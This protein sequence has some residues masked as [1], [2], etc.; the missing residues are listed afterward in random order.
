M[1][2]NEHELRFIAEALG[3]EYDVVRHG[4]PDYVITK[5][6]E[7]LFVEVKPEK[8][9][10]SGNAELLSVN[11][12]RMLRT[13]E[14]A[15]LKVRISIGGDL[16]QLYTLG[17]YLKLTKFKVQYRSR[18]DDTDKWIKKVIPLKRKVS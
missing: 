9:F 11:Q 2:K 16:D 6:D 12:V 10:W 17:E 14:K 1:I 15:G 7:I 5:G 8:R 18:K 13:M 3:R 4:W